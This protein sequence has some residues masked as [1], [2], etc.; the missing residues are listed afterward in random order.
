MIINNDGL[1]ID[2]KRN[3]KSTDTIISLYK[4]GVA[5]NIVDAGID[6][7]TI[8]DTDYVLYRSGVIDPDIILIS[9]NTLNF[10]LTN[11]KTFDCVP[12]LNMYSLS[13]PTLT[14]KLYNLIGIT[15]NA[16]N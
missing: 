13:Q 4:D 15:K 9:D 7:T 1:L 8:E 12:T 3:I 11:S 16:S 14:P 6:P 5:V 10:T 2:L